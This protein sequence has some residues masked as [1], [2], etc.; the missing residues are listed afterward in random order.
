MFNQES[1]GGLAVRTSHPHHLQPGGWVVVERCGAPRKRVAR[2]LDLDMRGS[3]REMRFLPNYSPGSAFDRFLDKT[4]A[5]YPIALDRTKLPAWS[6]L[7]RLVTK[8]ASI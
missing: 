8:P 5:I 7:A 6:D 4:M 1:R 3:C 2:V